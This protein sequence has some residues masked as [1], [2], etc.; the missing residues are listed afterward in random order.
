MISEEI[1]NIIINNLKKCTLYACDK[2]KKHLK[3]ARKYKDNVLLAKL[4]RK[5][6]KNIEE[7][8]KI[9]EL[10]QSYNKRKI[11]MN[12]TRGVWLRNEAIRRKNEWWRKIAWMSI[13]SNLQIV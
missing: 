7:E 4:V 8:F 6:Q 13:E 2:L 1:R 5:I 9:N 10:W 12:R 11:V 3:L